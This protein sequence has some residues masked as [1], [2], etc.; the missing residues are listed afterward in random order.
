MKQQEKHTHRKYQEKNE[1]SILVVI[2]P[3]TDVALVGQG[4]FQTVALPRFP[5]A[6]GGGSPRVRQGSE[7]LSE[8]SA[9][10]TGRRRPARPG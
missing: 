2:L 4:P 5:A 8:G 7:G 1:I 9:P 10:E 6:G 3:D